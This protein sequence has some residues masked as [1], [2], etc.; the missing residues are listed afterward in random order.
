MSPKKLLDTPFEEIRQT[1]RNYMSPKARV[2]TAQRAKFLSV[3]QSV[4]ES[5]D[6]FQARLREE[7]RYYL[8]EKPK[9]VTNLE[10]ELVKIKFI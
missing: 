6:T 7:A 2:E 8:F 9:T 10:E 5:D 1:I 3:V 4:R